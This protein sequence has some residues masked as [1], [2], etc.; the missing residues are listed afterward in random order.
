MIAVAGFNT[1]VDRLLEV[2]DIHVG[3]V[4]RARVATA[5][6]GGKGVHAALCAAVLGQEVELVGVIDEANAR[7]FESWLLERGVRFTG[8]RINQPVRSCLTI[9]DGRGRITEI[10]EPGVGVGETAWRAVRSSFVTIA[11]ASR[12]AVLSGSVPP[13][14]PHTI[15]RDIV[16]DLADAR[17]VVDAGG[18]LF[19][20][21]LEAKP[22]CVKPN[23]EEAEAVTGRALESVVQ[24]AAA[25]RDVARRAIPL[26]TVSMGAAGAVACWERRTC[27]IVPPAVSPRNVVGA[28]DCTT[29]ALAV[30]LARDLPIDEALRLAVAAGTA[31]TL[32]PEVGLV[33]RDDIERMLLEVR[34]TW[35]D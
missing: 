10:R 19:R 1:A 34:L 31:K 29:A 3:T 26:V 8:V 28:G 9:R 15:Y 11:R 32:S 16:R 14:V 6:P 12:V 35:L 5:W 13:D 7:W 30:A 27:H 23:R 17:V 2:E 20:A 22:F 18:D 4:M 21:A 25:A 24:A 33:R